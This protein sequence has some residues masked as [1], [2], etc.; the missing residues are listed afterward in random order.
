MFF[1]RVCKRFRNRAGSC[2]SRAFSIS[3][4]GT[5]NVELTLE[6]VQRSDTRSAIRSHE[7]Q[8]CPQEL[9]TSSVRPERLPAGVGVALFGGKNLRP[10]D[11]LKRRSGNRDRPAT[12]RSSWRLVLRTFAGVA[13]PPMPSKECLAQLI[14]RIDV[15]RLICD[16]Q[17]QNQRQR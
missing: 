14:S 16:L 5:V 7:R 17:C 11:A 9:S 10:G 12:R 1:R 8:R 6:G 15:T 2:L 4:A 3:A 13:V